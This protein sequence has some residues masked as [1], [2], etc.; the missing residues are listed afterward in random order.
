MASKFGLAADLFV[1]FKLVTADRDLKVVNARANQDLCWALRGGG[2]ETLGV[3]VE[4][5]MKA[6]P[7]LRT[8]TRWWIKTADANNIDAIFPTCKICLSTCEG[9]LANMDSGI[10]SKQAICA[11]RKRRSRLLLYLSNFYVWAMMMM[12]YDS[13]AGIHKA[14]KPWEPILSMAEKFPGMRKPLY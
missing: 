7:T 9:S 10:R 4:A 6:F 1:D 8:L 12:N 5:T 13:G 14:K 2:G 11:Q 3:V